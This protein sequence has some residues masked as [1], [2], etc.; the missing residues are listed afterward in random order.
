MHDVYCTK[1]HRTI[2]DCRQCLSMHHNCAFAEVLHWPAIV[3][4]NVTKQQQALSI[5]HDNIKSDIRDA[6]IAKGACVACETHIPDYVWK[7]VFQRL[8]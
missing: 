4:V 7:A 8:A 1:L 6:D 2:L 5:D 3:D